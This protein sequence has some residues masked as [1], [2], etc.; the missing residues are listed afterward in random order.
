MFLNQST[1]SARSVA[2]KDKEVKM[3]MTIVN[4][5]T[6]KRQGLILSSS[7]DAFGCSSQVELILHDLLDPFCILIDLLHL[8]DVIFPTRRLVAPPPSSSAP[9]GHVVSCLFSVIRRDT[10]ISRVHVYLSN[11]VL[12]VLAPPAP[13][14][15]HLRSQILDGKIGCLSSH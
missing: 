8:L 11:C 15:A 2:A 7:S 6:D 13:S 5:K 14:R 3:N 9:R 12:A 10:G 4:P 1:S